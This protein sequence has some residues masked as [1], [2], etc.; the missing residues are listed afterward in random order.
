[1]E[2]SETDFVAPGSEWQEDRA[3]GKPVKTDQ[4]QDRVQ[5]RLREAW[6]FLGQTNYPG[7]VLVLELWRS[8]RVRGR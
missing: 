5:W 8:S 6:T 3:R 2:E 4:G 7:K 1:V